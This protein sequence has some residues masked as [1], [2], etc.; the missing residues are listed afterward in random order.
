MSWTEET[1]NPVTGC[2]PI[3]EACRYCYAKASVP[4]QQAGRGG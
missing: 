1:W 4:L 3:S 2:T